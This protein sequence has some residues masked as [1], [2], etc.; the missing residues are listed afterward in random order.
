MGIP[1]L[2]IVGRFGFGWRGDR[3]NKK[4]LATYAMAIVALGLL[5]FEFIPAIG[6]WLIT[7]F[8]LFFG[9]GYGGSVAMVA[10]LTRHYFGRR[11]FGTILGCMQGIMTLGS[12]G[13]PTLAGWVFDTWRSYQNVWLIF[14]GVA[15][16]GAILLATTPLV[17]AKA[18]E[19]V[20]ATASK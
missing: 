16:I 11:N 14:A 18:G 5:S 2:S 1:L 8:L 3:V 20:P 4:R 7:P 6:T 12:I 13:M 9:I 17:P 15:M 19:P 10:I